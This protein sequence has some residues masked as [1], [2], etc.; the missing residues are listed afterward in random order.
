[1]ENVLEKKPIS[2]AS[3]HTAFM[4]NDPKSAKR[5]SSHHCLFVHLGSVR[6]KATPKT[7][8]KLTPGK[9]HRPSVELYKNNSRQLWQPCKSQLWQPCKPKSKHFNPDYF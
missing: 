1:L 4:R 3:L 8:V 2:P 5:Q 7:L 6:V 9:R